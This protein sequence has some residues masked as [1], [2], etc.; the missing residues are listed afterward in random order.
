MLTMTGSDG[1]TYYLNT[2]DGYIYTQ[3]FVE[4]GYKQKVAEDASAIV[5]PAS[6]SVGRLSGW[7][8]TSPVEICLKLYFF[9]SSS[10]CVPFPEPGAPNITM[11]FIL[12]RILVWR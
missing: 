1:N 4:K 12:E 8:G 9:T 6:D 2:K 11:F 3:D 10:L 7:S 5:D